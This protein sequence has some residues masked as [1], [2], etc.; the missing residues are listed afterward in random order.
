MPDPASGTAP[1]RAM[2]MQAATGD[3]L[4]WRALAASFLLRAPSPDVVVRM[5]ARARM[6]LRRPQLMGVIEEVVASL[7]LELGQSAG[8][9]TPSVNGGDRRSEAGL[10]LSLILSEL[11]QQGARLDA[12]ATEAGEA[13]ARQFAGTLDGA[14]LTPLQ[15]LQAVGQA[16]T[17]SVAAIEAAARAARRME[18]AGRSMGRSSMFSPALA[19]ARSRILDLARRCPARAESGGAVALPDLVRLMEIL[20]GP[21][22]ALAMIDQLA[23][24]A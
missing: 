13:L 16:G 22:A 6:S 4:V 5:I 3:L 14:V 11:S 19:G 20:A 9:T 8:I 15:Q 7:S 23:A 21:D 24:E 18:V 1:H 10:R 2:L 17:A 12:L